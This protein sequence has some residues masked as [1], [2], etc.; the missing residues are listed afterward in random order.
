MGDESNGRVTRTASAALTSRDLQAAEFHGYRP[1]QK[2]WNL[3]ILNSYLA[4]AVRP[5]QANEHLRWRQT[6]TAWACLMRTWRGHCWPV[7]VGAKEVS[8]GGVD[9]VRPC[10]ASFVPTSTRIAPAGR[11]GTKLESPPSDLG[12]CRLLGP[13]RC[14]VEL[15]PSRPRG[16]GPL[17]DRRSNSRISERFNRADSTKNRGCAPPDARKIS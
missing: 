1:V 2:I 17:C 4:E 5:G 14:R 12:A 15:R 6:I 9:L 10:K 11:T 8:A 3:V 13:G 16:I 7:S